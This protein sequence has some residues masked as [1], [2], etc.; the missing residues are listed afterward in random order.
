MSRTRV[1]AAAD[2]ELLSALADDRPITPERVTAASQDEEDEYDALLTAAEQG[3]VVVCAELDDEDGQIALRDVQSFH[4]DAD[5][6]GDLAWYA[7]QEIAQV[8]ALLG[9]R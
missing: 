4:V 8:I 6:S 9:E 7:P 5:A 2:A 1:Y 3:P